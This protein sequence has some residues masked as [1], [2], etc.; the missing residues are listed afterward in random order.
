ML[1]PSRLVV[2]FHLSSPT[3][4]A[5][6]LS[7]TN[8]RNNQ[9]SSSSKAKFD[10]PPVH[11]CYGSHLFLTYHAQLAKHDPHPGIYPYFFDIYHSHPFTVVHIQTYIQTYITTTSSQDTRATA[12]D[13]IS[14]LS[15]IAFLFFRSSDQIFPCRSM[16]QY[17]SVDRNNPKLI[18][19]WV[20]P[21]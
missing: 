1:F 7:P 20:I 6:A 19:V 12:F 3:C 2:L 11:V 14:F 9:S 16:A 4:A 13:I 5:I 10:Q 17:V 18:I 15:M 8:N 21:M